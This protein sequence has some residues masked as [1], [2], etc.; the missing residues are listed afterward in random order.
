MDGQESGTFLEDFIQSIELL[1]NDVRRNFGLMKELDRDATDIARECAELGSI[2][3][4]NVTASGKRDKTE[5][6]N[7][8]IEEIVTKRRK[9]EQNMNEKIAIAEQTLEIVE[10][11]IRKMDTDL[12]VFENL[13]RGSG[14]FESIGAEPGQEVKNGSLLCRSNNIVRLL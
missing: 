7:K 12:A 6:D 8:C 2:F 5:D 10:S 1:P 3:M 4:K 11:F 14:D 9:A 13:L